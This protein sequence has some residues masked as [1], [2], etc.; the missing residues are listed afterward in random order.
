MTFLN[1]SR[2]SKGL[3][4]LTLQHHQRPDTPAGDQ[5]Y[6]KDGRHAVLAG[7]V[8][9]R[10]L[11]ERLGGGTVR[12]PDGF[13]GP[14]I[15]DPD[16][17]GDVI[18]SF[19]WNHSTDE[20]DS[21]NPA[22][23]TGE[24]GFPGWRWSWPVVKVRKPKKGDKID[25]DRNR[26][27]AEL[28]GPAVP[29]RAVNR[30]LPV[31]PVFNPETGEFDTFNPIGWGGGDK[32]EGDVRQKVTPEKDKDGFIKCPHLN[33]HLWQPTKGGAY[34]DIDFA[35]KGLFTPYPGLK[36][37]IGHVGMA[38]SGT[39]EWDQDETYFPTDP[40]LFAVNN[41]S[42]TH[43]STQVC[44]VTDE[45]RIDHERKAKLHSFLR[46][47]D[48][49]PFCDK[50]GNICGDM[51]QKTL[52]WNITLSGCEDAYGG[53]VYDGRK[54]IAGAVEYD[55]LNGP[56]V[57]TRC[58]HKLT[59]ELSPHKTIV[60]K[61]PEKKDIHPLHIHLDAFFTDSLGKLDGPKHHN[62]LY[63]GAEKYPYSS[64]VFLEYDDDPTDLTH[65]GR[66]PFV[67][68]RQKGYHRWRATVPHN[69]HNP[70]ETPTFTSPGHGQVQFNAGGEGG[71]AGFD[72]NV[73][74]FSP[75]DVSL[76]PIA[77]DWADPPTSTT[78]ESTT[79]TTTPPKQGSESSYTIVNNATTTTNRSKCYMYTTLEQ[80]SNA[81]I[82]RPQH[83]SEHSLDFRNWFNQTPEA[84]ESEKEYTPAV[85]R[86][87]AFGHQDAGNHKG[88]HCPG[89]AYTAGT[90]PDGT[91]KGR[92]ECK[93]ADGGVMFMP[94]EYGMENY[95]DVIE[96]PA[97]Q[98]TS[99]FLM[100]PN[101]KLAF[102][103]PD[104]TTGK[105]STTA[106]SDSNGGFQMYVHT[107]GTLRVDTADGVNAFYVK[108]SGN[109][110]ITGAVDA[111]PSITSAG[112]GSYGG[113]TAETGGLSG[114]VVEAT[115]K[116]G[117]GYF[118]TAGSVSSG[119]VTTV[120]STTAL[121]QPTNITKSVAFNGAGGSGTIGT[122]S[123]DQA[124]LYTKAAGGGIIDLYFK[125]NYGEWKLN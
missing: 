65:D 9:G 81:F 11:P 55:G 106:H 21:G 96:D 36:F 95:A 118:E 77:F 52:A 115:N 61:A 100:A 66:H 1:E 67:C 57:L 108:E 75:V 4:F 113:T 64:Q 13:I 41:I 53:W 49:G 35:Q 7:R 24:R 15:A 79:T 2:N 38:M 33:D 83:I 103:L 42:D 62:G 56:F 120:G 3:G 91:H 10:I 39:Y 69:T 122:V 117:G 94:P 119:T 16:S 8:F 80:G 110:V 93:S 88:P 89:W 114:L 102:G 27:G 107:D 111:V 99:T 125:N 26:L 25:D 46:V 43:M 60:G 20:T 78:E 17:F 63:K 105:L 19:L 58:K 54:K 34:Q 59:E 76:P 14:Y 44:D 121:S 72:P 51:D 48:N 50:V 123:S 6:S 82:F 71:G 12:D 101:T 73:L 23:P 112:K 109:V 40:R 92:Y 22:G 5:Q 86:L 47:I 74:A 70:P 98:S 104:L 45:F 68:E 37:P 84:V 90:Q 97:A 85:A 32:N 28:V 31:V 87:E 116:V 18:G 30:G 29:D 124:F